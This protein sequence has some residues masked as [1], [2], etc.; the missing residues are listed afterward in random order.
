MNIRKGV[1]M[2]LKEQF[3]NEFLDSDD[4]YKY[5]VVDLFT[6]DNVKADDKILSK[7]QLLNLIHNNKTEFRDVNI[8]N[9]IALLNNTRL[10]KIEYL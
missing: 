2:T 9:T 3:Y 1:I 4:M 8:D 7:E 6:K 10:I 5:V